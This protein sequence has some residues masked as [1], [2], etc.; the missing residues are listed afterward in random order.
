MNSF[1]HLAF[2]VS[3]QW[4]VPVIDKR[5]QIC[6]LLNCQFA[7]IMWPGC[8]NLWKVSGFLYVTLPVRIWKMTSPISL[9]KVY[10]KGATVTRPRVLHYPCGFLKPCPL[11]FKLSFCKLSSS[12][13]NTRVSYVFCQ[14]P[15]GYIICFL[16]IG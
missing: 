10:S 11:L 15:G 6:V 3:G 12:L 4:E 13:P 1:S 9:D 14:D 2:V 5:G 8:V 7:E 16:P